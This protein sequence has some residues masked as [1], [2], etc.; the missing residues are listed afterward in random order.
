M[1]LQIRD[2]VFIRDRV[3]NTPVLTIASKDR[4]AKDERWVFNTM[5]VSEAKAL[6]EFL[7]N[8]LKENE[9]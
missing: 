3:E 6:K 1:E 9:S 4:E 2:F 7:S 5:T 8:F